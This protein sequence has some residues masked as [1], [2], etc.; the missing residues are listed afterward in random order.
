MILAIVGSRD[1]H[2][3]S[4]IKGKVLENFNISEITEIVSGGAKGVDEIAERISKE[5]GI[6]LHIFRAKWHDLS[7]PDARIK[8]G[9]R[10][11][12]YDANAGF[13]RNRKIVQHASCVI[14][15]QLNESSGTADSIRL[16]KEM[17]KKAIVIKI[18]TG[19]NPV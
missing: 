10:G 18:D 19:L 9:L 5:F 11:V 14:A 12:D 1:F 2:D 4:F 3:Y 17:S 6:D 7:Q 16:A 8:K 15:F 13:R